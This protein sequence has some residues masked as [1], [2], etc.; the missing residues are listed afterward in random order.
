MLMIGVMALAGASVGFSQDKGKDK[1]DKEDKTPPAFSTTDY[2]LTVQWFKKKV[3]EHAKVGLNEI[4]ANGVLEEIEK[5]V[6]KHKNKT[7]SWR[8]PVRAIR[9]SDDKRT[10]FVYLLDF[11]KTVGAFGITTYFSVL[12]NGSPGMIEVSADAAWLKGVKIG[13]DATPIL[14]TGT[15]ESCVVVKGGAL[16]DGLKLYLSKCTIEP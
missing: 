4:A 8:L 6:A 11:P 9:L 14:L 1:G 7:V 16:F 3:A 12:L 2:P 10:A 15:V 13:K 5:E